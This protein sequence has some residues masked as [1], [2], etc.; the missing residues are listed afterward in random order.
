MFSCKA[1]SIKMQ[2]NPQYSHHSNIINLSAHFLNSC[3]MKNMNLPLLEPS[4]RPAAQLLPVS[5]SRIDSQVPPDK[6]IDYDFNSI[7]EFLDS[8]DQYF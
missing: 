3:S 5:E 7:K 6:V 2:K 8:C 1:K 4:V